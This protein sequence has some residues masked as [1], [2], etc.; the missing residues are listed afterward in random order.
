M[1][2]SAGMRDHV[3]RLSLVG[4]PSGLT[5]V[6]AGPASVGMAQADVRVSLILLNFQISVLVI[7]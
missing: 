4:T 1:S 2:T 6:C 7:D 3:Q 5:T